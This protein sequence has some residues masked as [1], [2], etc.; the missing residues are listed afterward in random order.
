MPLQH[1]T[2]ILFFSSY[3][4]L[5]LHTIREYY[6]NKAK[7]N[8]TI[9]E[10]TNEKDIPPKTDS[11]YFKTIWIY[12]GVLPYRLHWPGSKCICP[13]IISAGRNNE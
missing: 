2:S 1:R 12:T 5:S 6:S 3:F 9:K 4:Q 7:N 11:H 8:I 10:R 13:K